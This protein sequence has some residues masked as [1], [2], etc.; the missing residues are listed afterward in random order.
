MILRNTIFNLFS[1]FLLPGI[2][3]STPSD[4]ILEDLTNYNVNN[5]AISYENGN[6]YYGGVT[7][8]FSEASNANI[9]VPHGRG[10][11]RDANGMEVHDGMYSKGKITSN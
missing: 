3:S 9:S 7:E 8:I 6:K 10:T 2:E 11:M 4:F 1:L 5:P